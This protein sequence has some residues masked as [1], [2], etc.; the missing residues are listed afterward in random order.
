MKVAK[1][2]VK[3][4]ALYLI[5]STVVIVGIGIYQQLSLHDISVISDL[6]NEA[7]SDAYKISNL[8]NYLTDAETGQRG[9]LLT[10]DESYLKPYREALQKIPVAYKEMEVILQQL[11]GSAAEMKRVEELMNKKMLE[12]AKTIELKKRGKSS[13]ALK[14]VNSGDGQTYMLELR[15]L[16]K[17]M[18]EDQLRLASERGRKKE[19]IV[20]R[21]AWI[22]FLGSL[23]EVSLV[24]FLFYLL[25]RNQ[26]QRAKVHRSLIE[27]NMNLEAQGRLAAQVI[28]IQNEIG[29]AVDLDKKTVMD[30]VVKLSARL[31]EADGAIIEI[32]EGDELVYDH[33]YGAAN[34]FLGLRLKKVGSFSGLCLQERQALNCEDSELDPRVDIVACRKV[35]VRS[36]IVVPLMHYGKIIGVLKNYSSRPNFFSEEKFNALKIITGFLS[37]ALAQA[38]EFSEKTLAIQNLERVQADLVASTEKVNKATEAK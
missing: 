15:T 23:L 29:S 17:T 18:E 35:N 31:T 12:L 8:E 36:M 34:P 3:Q 30:L 13:E 14:L 25:Y 20:D 6:C 26:I 10:G 28:E 33:V 11:H 21:G 22:L 4:L 1:K 7:R 38:Q 16:L 2:F 27:A 19:A 24:I 5:A 9:Y 32:L 37:G